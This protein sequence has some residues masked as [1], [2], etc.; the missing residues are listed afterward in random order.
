MDYPPWLPQPVNTHQGR[1]LAIARCV[2]QL[3]Y[4]EVHHLEKGRVRTF[5]NLCVGPLQLAA[6][7]LHRSGFTVYSDEIQRFSSFVCDP[8]DFETVAKAKAAR[9][10]DRELV[11]TAVIRLSEEGFGATEEID[12][13]ARQLRAEG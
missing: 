7:V 6:E 5:D 4:R 3:H 9:D 2:H 11:R 13:L 12:W 1:L 10:L 8:A